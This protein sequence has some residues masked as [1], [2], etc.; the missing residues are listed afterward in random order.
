[1]KKIFLT[2]G[3]LFFGLKGFSQVGI[4]CNGTGFVCYPNPTTDRINVRWDRPGYINYELVDGK[5]SIVRQDNLSY[6]VY[7]DQFI[8]DVLGLIPGMYR[9]NVWVDGNYDKGCQVVVVDRSCH[10]K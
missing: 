9:L 7:G 10:S 8:I 6:K 1:M 2:L 3:F 4:S 5:G